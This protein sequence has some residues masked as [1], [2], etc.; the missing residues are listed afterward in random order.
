MTLVLG[1]LENVNEMGGRD[2]H[3]ELSQFLGMH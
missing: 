2:H 3:S 1:T